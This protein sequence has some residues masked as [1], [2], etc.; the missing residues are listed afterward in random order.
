MRQEIAYYSSREVG[1]SVAKIGRQVG[2]CALALAKE[3]EKR[4]IV[5]K[6]LVSVNVIPV[7]SKECWPS[8]EIPKSLT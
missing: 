2:V 8:P 1:A 4:E 7:L 5:K 6:G 3:I